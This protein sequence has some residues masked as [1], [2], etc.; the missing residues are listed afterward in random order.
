MI[1][2]YND[3]IKTLLDAGFSMA[4]GNDDGIYAVIPW[5]WLEDRPYGSP[6]A[7]HTGDFETD[8][9]EWRIRVLDERD[10]IAYAKLFF[11]KTGFITK[12]WYHYFLAARRGAMSF[13]ELYEDGKMSH[14]AKRIYDTLTEY[15]VLASHEI[16]ELASFSR[17]DKA[18]F[19]RAMVELQ[20]SMFITTCGARQKVSQTGEEYGWSSAVFCTVEQFFGERMMDKAAQINAEEAFETI[21]AQVYELNPKADE[22]KVRKF[23]FG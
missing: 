14:F 11:K 16:K 4:G 18:A 19:E 13:R 8:P 9:W 7:W 17:E 12:D 2:N 1:Q 20:M 5:G 22:K 10:D 6:I 15:Q 21:R 3:F 23:V